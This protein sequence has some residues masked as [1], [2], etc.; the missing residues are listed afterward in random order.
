MA[1]L[2]VGG[3]LPAVG[4]VLAPVFGLATEAQANAIAAQVAALTAQVA[5]LPTLAQHNA[6]AAQVAALPTLAQI[7]ASIAAAIAAALVPHNAPAI[8]ATAS[9]TVQAITSARVRNAHDRDD[10]YTIVP[11][12]DGTAPPHW[13]GGFNRVALLGNVAIIDALLLDYG[14]PVGVPVLNRRNALAVY[15]GTTRL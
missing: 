7:N 10:A 9:V 11:L 14:L 15:I 6:L 1:A 5:A 13:P 3:G 2:P 8:A 12:A 4:A